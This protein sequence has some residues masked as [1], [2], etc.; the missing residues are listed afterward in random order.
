MNI[1]PC[2]YHPC[3]HTYIYTPILFFGS[4]MIGLI[5][6]G[7]KFVIAFNTMYFIWFLSQLYHIGILCFNV[8]K[9]SA[10]IFPNFG[11]H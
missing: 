10:L 11:N 6:D 5:K 1:H 4:K 3:M 2:V 8:L 9:K 7:T